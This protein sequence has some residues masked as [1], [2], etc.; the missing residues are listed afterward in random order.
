[1]PK[2]LEEIVFR[3]G[4]QDLYV[5]MKCNAKIRSTKQKVEAGKTKCRKC[6]SKE[7]RLKAKERRGLTA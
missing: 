2:K 4:F 7:L 6:A 3:R 1:M 5:C